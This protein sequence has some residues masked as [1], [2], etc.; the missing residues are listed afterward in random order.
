MHTSIHEL[1]NYAQTQFPISLQHLVIHREEVRVGNWHEDIEI[2]YCHAGSGQIMC[3]SVDYKFSQGDLFVVNSNELHCSKTNF[4]MERY[5]LMI[6]STFLR[7]NHIDP[8]QLEFHHTPDDCMATELFQKIIAEFNGSSTYKNASIRVLVLSLIL[9]LAKFHSTPCSV[10]PQ[11][12]TAIK[13]AIGYLQSNYRKHITLNEL[14]AA[15]GLSKYHLTRKF[16]TATGIT[17]VEYL[18]IIRCQNAQRLL[19]KNI[20]TVSEVAEL[21]GFESPSYFSKIFKKTIGLCPS[22]VFDSFKQ[23]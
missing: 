4:V 2:L 20:Y 9:H 14:A 6:D 7:E 19:M 18:T 11:N 8:Q 16:K 13:I 12:D 23:S 21:C 17:P 1:H 10:Q 22:A 15:V 5:C 3:N